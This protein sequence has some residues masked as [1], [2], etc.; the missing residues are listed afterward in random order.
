MKK[1]LLACLVFFA[2]AMNAQDNNSGRS[3]GTPILPQQFESWVSQ[4]VSNASAKPGSGS[5]QTQSVFNIPV[6]VH[7][8]HNNEAVNTAFAT[9]GNNLNAAQVVDQ[10]NILNKDFN[11]TN[12]DTILIPT[13]FKPLMGKF[14]VNFCLAVVNPTGG[15]LAEPGIDRIN[16]IAKGWTGLPYSSTYIDN[17]VKPNSIWDPNRYLNVWVCPL[18]GGLLGYATFPNPGTSGLLG[19]TGSFGSATTDGVV[20]LNTAFG[21]IGTGQFGQYNRG[22]TATH[23]V[24]HWIGL[25]HI[26]GDNNCATDY[27]NDT[28]PAQNSNFGC[29]THPYKLG[30]CTGNTTGEMTMNYMDYTNDA[31]MYMFSADQG[32]RAQLILTNS[33][34]RAALITSTVCNLPTLPL[35][36]GISFVSAPGYSQVICSNYINPTINLTNYGATPI[37]NAILSFNVD[38]VNTQTM[39]WNGS[40]AP[41]SSV[42]VNL[43]QINFANAGPHVFNVS[44]VS[45][46]GGIDNNSSNNNNSQNFTMNNTLTFNAPSGQSCLGIPL[47]VTATGANSYSWSTGA[48]TASVALNPSVTTIYT[49]I[50][51]TGSCSSV[52]LVTVTV[53]PAPVLAVNTQSVCFNEPATITASGASTY[54]WNTGAGSSSISVSLSSPGNYTVTGFSGPACFASL[55]FSVSVKPRPTTTVVASNVSCV[56]CANGMVSVSASGATAPYSYTWMPG[57]TNAAVV[58][59]ATIGCY[60][61]TVSDALGCISENFA[62]VSYDVGLGDRLNKNAFIKVTPNPTKGEFVIEGTDD[63]SLIEIIDALGRLVKQQHTLKGTV[64]LDLSAEAAGVYYVRI[65]SGSGLSVVKLVKE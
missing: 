23:E 46:N 21:S 59:G 5:G 37:T 32:F 28:P 20:I 29:P 26:W 13:V 19:L 35:D 18:S 14:G 24:G 45:P 50:A 49:V 8:I 43:P 38:G 27:C 9:S 63:G 48:V 39:T 65:I 57:N 7:I 34:M 51:T 53:V 61:V 16:R 22:R 2:F 47:I 1:N 25:R 12:A 64:K 4:L 10:I 52:K 62:C 60:T 58:N 41:N 6:I 11:G 54:S 3:C 55:V 33:L 56:S 42:L 44:V 40:L 30:V 31:C 15:V 17:T 36:A